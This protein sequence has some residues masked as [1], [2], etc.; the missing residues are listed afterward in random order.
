MKLFSRSNSEETLMPPPPPFPSVEDSLN[1]SQE[2]LEF[3]SSDDFSS[4]EIQN[5]QKEVQDAI[6]LVQN[7]KKPSLFNCQK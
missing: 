6:T 7:P 2:I 1:S 3:P 5:A 4:S